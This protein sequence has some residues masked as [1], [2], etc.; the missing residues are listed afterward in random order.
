MITNLTMC[1]HQETAIVV[2]INMKLT[3]VTIKTTYPKNQR[4]T[5]GSLSLAKISTR[6]LKMT[7]SSGHVSTIF[8]F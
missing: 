4:P 6:V 1:I 3:G 7:Q 2:Q 5:R 8:I